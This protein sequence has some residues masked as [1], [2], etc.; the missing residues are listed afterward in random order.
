MTFELTNTLQSISSN[1]AK[2][3]KKGSAL[4]AAEYLNVGCCPNVFVG[5][6]GLATMGSLQNF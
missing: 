6:L 1:L 2:E 5:G 3:K 4:T